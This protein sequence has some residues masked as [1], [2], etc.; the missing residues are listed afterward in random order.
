MKQQ[1]VS[2]YTA[3]HTMPFGPSAAWFWVHFC[4]TV[5][6]SCAHS[7][8]L[9]YCGSNYMFEFKGLFSQFSMSV[10]LWWLVALSTPQTCFS[11]IHLSVPKGFLSRS[12]HRFKKRKRVQ[13]N[14]I[15]QDKNTICK[16]LKKSPLSKTLFQNSSS[17][18][19]GFLSS[20]V[21]KQN[22]CQFHHF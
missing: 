8:T 7:G 19:S 3:L 11:S 4:Q 6:L 14:A 9:A 12:K 13:K 1:F 16:F 15:Y 2:K 20:M 22:V 18:C 17:P 10:L 21:R 5:L